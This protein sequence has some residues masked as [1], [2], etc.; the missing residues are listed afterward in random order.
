MVRW[1]CKRLQRLIPHHHLGLARV[2]V[3]GSSLR[4]QGVLA[5]ITERMRF[6]RR[7]FGRNV[8]DRFSRRPLRLRHAEG[9]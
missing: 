7:R 1:K 5:R 2:V 3:I 4:K 6:A 8:G 9:L